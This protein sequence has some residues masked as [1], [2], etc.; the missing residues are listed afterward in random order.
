MSQLMVYV[1]ESLNPRCTKFKFFWASQRPCSDSLAWDA[2]IYSVL[3]CCRGNQVANASEQ[4]LARNWKVAL[5]GVEPGRCMR[6]C[7]I[8][9]RLGR[10]LSTGIL[11][12]FSGSTRRQILPVALLRSPC[13]LGV[14]KQDNR[15]ISSYT[16]ASTQQC[17]ESRTGVMKTKFV[18]PEPWSRVKLY[19]TAIALP[20]LSLAHGSECTR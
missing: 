15:E 11:Y 5:R 13:H 18:A 17:V 14:W 10:N 9:C 19:S 16:S 12:F 20:Y 4:Q 1:A 3:F 6:I 2:M 8:D 7:S